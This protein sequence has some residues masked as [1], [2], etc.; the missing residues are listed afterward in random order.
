MTKAERDWEGQEKKRMGG[1]E[2]MG[3]DMGREMWHGMPPGC[4][5]LGAEVLREG[6]EMRESV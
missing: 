6:K 2:R 1:Q 3:H 5:V 4:M